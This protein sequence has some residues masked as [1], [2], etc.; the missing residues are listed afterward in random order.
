MHLDPVPLTYISHSI[1]FAR[2]RCDIDLRGV[3]VLCKSC[4]RL[5]VS[6]YYWFQAGRRKSETSL[7]VCQGTTLSPGE[8][9]NFISVGRNLNQWYS[10]IHPGSEEELS[11]E[12]S[13]SPPKGILYTLL[14]E[15]LYHNNKKPIK[16]LMNTH[17]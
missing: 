2:C 15:C 3:L 8:D 1:D 17:T 5:H 9:R 12:Q 10:F 6:L 7:D 16:A 13:V 4:Y 11:F 14:H